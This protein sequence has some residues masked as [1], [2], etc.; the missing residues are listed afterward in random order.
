MSL[1]LLS[2]N[3]NK[4]CKSLFTEGIVDTRSQTETIQ[5]SQQQFLLRHYFKLALHTQKHGYITHSR[6]HTFTF[7]HTGSPVYSYTAARGFYS[8]ATNHHHCLSTCIPHC[9]CPSN[10]SIVFKMSTCC[11]EIKLFQVNN[12]LY[13]ISAKCFKLSIY[14]F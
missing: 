9:W 13:N 14:Q 3:R 8:S 10:D 5:N 12:N 6:M 11:S 4:W 2:V 7:K 1:N